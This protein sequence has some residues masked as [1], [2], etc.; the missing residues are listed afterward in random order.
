MHLSE[1]LVETL[2]DAQFHGELTQVVEIGQQRGVGEQNPFGSDGDGFTVQVDHAQA[3]GVGGTEETR[4]LAVVGGDHQV[5]EPG[6]PRLIG[7]HLGQHSPR[8]RQGTQQPA[9]HLRPGL[10]VVGVQEGQGRVQVL[11]RRGF[12]RGWRHRGQLFALAVPCDDHAVTN[13]Q[14]MS[15]AGWDPLHAPQGIGCL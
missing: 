9:F 7:P 14:F 3:A 4:H 13:R 10:G 6:T 8:H 12:P 11:P 1:Q 15:G 2:L 5:G